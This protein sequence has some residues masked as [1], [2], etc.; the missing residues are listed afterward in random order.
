M[1]PP[2][3]GRERGRNGGPSD[4]VGDSPRERTDRPDGVGSPPFDGATVAADDRRR[5]TNAGSRPSERPWLPDCLDCPSPNGTVLEPPSPPRWPRE[6]PWSVDRLLENERIADPAGS[7]DPDGVTPVP[8]AADSSPTA[9]GGDSNGDGVPDGGR[10]T[11]APRCE[12]GPRVPAMGPESEPSRRPIVG[13]RSPGSSASPAGV[14]SRSDAVGCEGVVW[15]PL[16][17]ER[18]DG[19]TVTGGIDS[20]EWDGGWSPATAP[21]RSDAWDTRGAIDEESLRE[22]AGGPSI[23]GEAVGAST[24]RR[25]TR[26]VTVVSGSRRRRPIDSTRGD[27]IGLDRPDARSKP[28]LPSVWSSISS[29]SPSSTER[30]RGV[31]T[32]GRSSM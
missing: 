12:R 9:R 10:S 24:D 30:C 5:T 7:T 19:D 16:R 29:P 22:A 11:V 8:T 31:G 32:C 21:S 20:N 17:C 23:A 13:G 1:G 18:G 26:S 14:G 2:L 15:G 28:V 25:G 4:R 6:R 3:S 27:R